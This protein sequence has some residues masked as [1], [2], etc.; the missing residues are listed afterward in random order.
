[1]P[2]NGINQENVTENRFKLQNKESLTLFGLDNYL[3]FGA[4]FLDRSLNR[5]VGVDP[6]SHKWNMASPYVN[7]MNNSVRYIDPDGRE[8]DVRDIYR[9]NKNKTYIHP[10]L[11]NAFNH[12]ANSKIGK[13]FLSQFAAAGQNIAGHVYKTNG[14][15]H[16][17]G[18]DIEYNSNKPKNIRASG[19]TSVSNINGRTKIEISVEPGKPTKDDQG[20][21]FL[22]TINHET[23]IHARRIANDIYHSGKIDYSTGYDK[24]LVKFARA[25]KRMDALDHYQEGRDKT[26]GKFA[27]PIISTYPNEFIRNKN[28][29]ELKNEM[30]HF[31]N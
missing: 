4:R 14:K 15:F 16:N 8:I 10:N 12:F 19:E 3:D 2:L 22:G 18:I 26:F 1:M 21:S 7:T 27:Y 20:H 13:D 6:L 24:D 28:K 11:V 5:W 25:E 30:Y 9:K 23:F 29:T 31:R 17:A